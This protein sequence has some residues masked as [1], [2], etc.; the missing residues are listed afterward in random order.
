MRQHKLRTE[1]KKQNDT[2]VM[3]REVKGGTKTKCYLKENQLSFSETRLR[4]DSVEKHSEFDS[5][6]FDCT[7]EDGCSQ[8]KLTCQDMSQSESSNRSSRCKCHCRFWKRP[9]QR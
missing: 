6:A 3:H 8:T 7:S 5:V 9:S 4:M 1:N 2:E